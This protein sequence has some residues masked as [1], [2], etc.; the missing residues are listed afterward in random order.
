MVSKPKATSRPPAQVSVSLK[1]A[2]LCHKQGSLQQSQLRCPL[3]LV[4][5]P[6]HTSKRPPLNSSINCSHYTFSQFILFFFFFLCCSYAKQSHQTKWLASPWP[7][8]KLFIFPQ[9]PFL[10]LSFIFAI[11]PFTQNDK[12]IYIQFGI[13][14]GCFINYLWLIVRI[15]KVECKVLTLKLQLDW[16]WQVESCVIKVYTRFYK[17][18]Y[19]FCVTHTSSFIFFLFPL[20]LWN[21]CTFIYIWLLIIPAW[22]MTSFFKML[23]LRQSAAIAA[24]S[25]SYGGYICN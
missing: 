21:T 3:R 25:D 22:H 18:G 7:L 13:Y 15:N 1:Y 20:L 24:R 6:S 9:F 4:N 5:L 2:T 17:S 12:Y 19:V 11:F 23:P 8:S 10:V 16:S 14:E